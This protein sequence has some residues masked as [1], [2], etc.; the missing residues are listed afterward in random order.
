MQD[1]AGRM[2]VSHKVCHGELPIESQGSERIPLI[3]KLLLREE[4]G[5][6]PW[7]MVYV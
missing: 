7:S 3:S 2:E 5:S 6:N 1:V 4:S